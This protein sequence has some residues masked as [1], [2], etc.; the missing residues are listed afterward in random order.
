MSSFELVEPVSGIPVIGF[1]DLLWLKLQAGRMRDL[2][3]IMQLC[4]I[5]LGK[6]DPDRV[7]RRLL[8]EDTDL[9]D[10][11]LD[12]IRKAPIEIANEQR[13]GQGLHPNYKQKPS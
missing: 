5:H 7:L 8:P 9:R 11:L 4:K 6:I 3:D 1:N 10:T 13:L 12:I 2:A